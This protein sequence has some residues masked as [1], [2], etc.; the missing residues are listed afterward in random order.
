[1]QAYSTETLET[2]PISLKEDKNEQNSPLPSKEHS[3]S[4]LTQEQTKE[5]ND[6]IILS[7]PTPLTIN[8][9]PLLVSEISCYIYIFIFVISGF[10]FPRYHPSQTFISQPSLSWN[11][12]STPFIFMHLTDLH[13]S[14]PSLGHTIDYLSLI[15]KYNS[16]LYLITGDLVDNYGGK[17]ARPKVGYQ[18]KKDWV[19]YKHLTKTILGDNATILDIAG[20]HD[21]FALDSL[22]AK[23]NYFLDYSYTFNRNNTLTKEDFLC[24]KVIIKNLTFI[25]INPYSFPTVHPPFG[26]WSKPSSSDLDLFENVIDNAGDCYVALHYTVDQV[27]RWKRSSKGHTFEQIMQKKNIKAIFT[28]H[29]HPTEKRII[30]HKKGGVEYVGTGPYNNGGFNIV[31]ID[32]GNLVYHTYW[33]NNINKYPLFIITYPVPLDQI[34]NHH[35]FNNKHTE[36]RVVSFTDKPLSLKVKGDVEGTLNLIKQ[37]DNGSFLYSMPLDLEYGKYSIKVYTDE[38]QYYEVKRKFIIGDTYEGKKEISICH[39][40][41]FYFLKLASPIIFISIFIPLLPIPN[42]ILKFPEVDLWIKGKSNNSHWIKVLLLSPFIIRSRIL[43]LNT[44]VRYSLFLSFIYILIMP[45]HFYAP[46]NG[47]VAYSF[48]VFLNLKGTIWYDEWALFMSLIYL[49]TVILPITLYASA[50]EFKDKSFVYWFNKLLLIGLCCLMCFANY[51]YVSESV[52]LWALFLNP[53]FVLIPLGLN[54]IL[55][56]QQEYVSKNKELRNSTVD[57]IINDVKS[58]GEKKLFKNEKPCQ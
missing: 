48:F 37:L 54:I 26:F 32:N 56:T 22:F 13:I 16:E 10:C 17:T 29:K 6:I 43:K 8:S 57:S 55:Y 34:S 1:M 24:K 4:N 50:L 49:I 11:S 15:A 45:H 35:M 18:T 41:F 14:I 36:I 44:F 42:H 19:Y 2:K 39:Q 12:N 40:R 23:H 51:R 30:H 3:N 25:L 21:M 7:N 46:I 38:G 52:E 31:S 9:L 20:N 53:I 28:G 5:T 33:L 47:K 27:W 58:V